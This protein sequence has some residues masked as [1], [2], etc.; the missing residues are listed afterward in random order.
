MWSKYPVTSTYGFHMIL[1]TG[2]W[3]SKCSDVLNMVRNASHACLPIILVIL[4]WYTYSCC[5]LVEEEEW[6]LRLDSLG[7]DSHSFL[8]VDNGLALLAS[9][10]ARNWRSQVWVEL[11]VDLCDLSQSIGILSAV[12]RVLWPWDTYGW[13]T[14]FITSVTST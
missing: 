6:K 14:A 5:L 11:G 9:P 13:E 2:T 4:F 8:D 1:I 12:R 7:K 3:C 10:A